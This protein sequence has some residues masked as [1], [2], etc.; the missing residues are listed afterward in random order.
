M[1]FRTDGLQTT[2]VLAVWLAALAGCQRGPAVVPVSGIV[3]VDGQPLASGA[4][5]VVPANGRPASG[6]IGPDGRF[7]LSSFAVGDGVVTGTHQVVVIA[8]EDLG[9]GRIRW[10]VPTECRSL[11]ASSLRLEVKGRTTEAK[12]SISTNGRPLPVENVFTK[13]DIAPDGRVAE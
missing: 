7:T 13:G 6:T 10:L 5:T 9:A 1:R 4:I 11:E 2:A 3:E 12:V 8:H